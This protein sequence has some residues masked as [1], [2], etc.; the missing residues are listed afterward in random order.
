MTYGKKALSRWIRPDLLTINQLNVISDMLQ[1]RPTFLMSFMTQLCIAYR[2]KQSFD[3]EYIQRVF[4]QFVS[5]TRAAVRD[6]KPKQ[7][8]NSKARYLEITIY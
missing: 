4:N 6:G 1:G 2:D 3:S 8:P 7:Q 5:D